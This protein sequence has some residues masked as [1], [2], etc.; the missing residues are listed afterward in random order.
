PAARFLAALV[1]ANQNTKSNR[2][3]KFGQR[4]DSCVWK[5]PGRAAGPPPGKVTCWVSAE[6]YAAGEAETMAPAAQNVISSSCV[7]FRISTDCTRIASRTLA[8]PPGI[9]STNWAERSTTR[10]FPGRKKR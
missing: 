8:F 9:Q 10:R 1:L 4:T 5:S 2:F 6:L 3:D 7:S